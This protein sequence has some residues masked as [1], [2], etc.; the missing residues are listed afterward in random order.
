MKE[1]TVTSY[2]VRKN[3]IYDFRYYS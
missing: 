3:K 1:N 2:A